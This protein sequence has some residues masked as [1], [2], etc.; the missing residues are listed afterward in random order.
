MDHEKFMR[1]HEKRMA[2]IDARLE[3][4]AELAKEAKAKRLARDEWYR[5]LRVSQ[6]RSPEPRIPEIS[7]RER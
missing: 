3:R 5:A 4:I 2:R 6:G 7:P 1:G